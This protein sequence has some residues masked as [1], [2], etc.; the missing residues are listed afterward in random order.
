MGPD[1]K[2]RSGN[3]G[4]ASEY[5]APKSQWTPVKCVFHKKKIH[6]WSNSF[7]LENKNGR[8]CLH[9]DPFPMIQTIVFFPR[10]PILRCKLA[11]L[12]SAPSVSLTF[13]PVRQIPS[14][15]MKTYFP[16]FTVLVLLLLVP[17][18]GLDMKFDWI[19]SWSLQDKP[20]NIG[21][22]K[23]IK[24]LLYLVL[25]YSRPILLSTVKPV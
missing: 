24:G 6:K 22:F 11:V 20:G 13:L 7:Y 21:S 4:H 15:N 5:W 3:N 9:L 14:R 23:R 1:A 10:S 19:S 8:F 16:E 17:C 12:L 18:L 2:L 25:F